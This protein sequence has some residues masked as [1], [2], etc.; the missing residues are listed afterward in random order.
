MHVGALQRELTVLAEK[1]TR[2]ATGDRGFTARKQQLE[3]NVGQADTATAD[4]SEE[5]EVFS[6]IPEGLMMEW[7]ER[8]A[9]WE[10][11]RNEQSR[12]Q[13]DFQRTKE[14]NRKNHTAA[15]A[16]ALNARQK[17]ERLQARTT[18]LTEQ[19]KRLTSSVI[20]PDSQ[21]R[22]QPDHQS[23]RI[24]ERNRTENHYQ[25]QISALERSYQEARFRYQ[26][27]TSQRNALEQAAE[28]T[29]RQQAAQQA[30][31]AR[32]QYGS[33]SVTPEG[34]LP[35][36][37]PNVSK[38][39]SQPYSRFGIFTTPESQ[40]VT[41]A[42][43]FGSAGANDLS[44]NAS[45]RRRSQSAISGG[46]AYLDGLDDDDDDPIPAQHKRKSG[47]GNVLEGSDGRSSGSSGSP[48]VPTLPP[49]PPIG[50]RSMNS[51]PATGS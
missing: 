4:I 18:K 34:D 28:E 6:E 32:L 17:K 23:T 36:T 22:T 2:L 26:T 43:A 38:N 8:K 50:F 1:L 45:Y 51:P 29:A 41:P 14:E 3:Q 49:V 33:R 13:E 44:R 31:Q 27:I 21:R 25:D 15:Q 12:V 10:Q 30:Q 35:G 9:N 11:I 42:S 20:A 39:H 37:N 19:H 40:S 47:I 7:Q 46:S 5:L 16:E 48:R 24:A